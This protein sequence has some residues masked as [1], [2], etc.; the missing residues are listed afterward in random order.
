MS[1]CSHVFDSRLEGR[2]RGREYGRVVLCGRSVGCG[3][4]IPHGCIMYIGVWL[5]GRERSH[6]PFFLDYCVYLAFIIIH[7]I[8]RRPS[9]SVHIGRRSNM[10]EVGTD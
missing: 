10:V 5:S 3:R 4:K 2:P 7:I 9:F 6:A 1:F 8:V